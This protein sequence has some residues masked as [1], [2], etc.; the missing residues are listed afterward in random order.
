MT[1]AVY[2]A[3]PDERED[4]DNKFICIILGCPAEATER[5]DLPF[6]EYGSTLFFLC[7][8]CLEKIQRIRSA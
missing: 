2:I 5:L 1:H 7:K 3:P 6:G 4:T 8:N